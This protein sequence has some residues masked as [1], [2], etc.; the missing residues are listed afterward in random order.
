MVPTA[1]MNDAAGARGV[2][3][4]GNSGGVARKALHA[5]MKNNQTVPRINSSLQPW[6]LALSFSLVLA[7]AVA[8]ALSSHA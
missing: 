2:G 1:C 7:L 4:R 5:K 6:P 3:K 8:L